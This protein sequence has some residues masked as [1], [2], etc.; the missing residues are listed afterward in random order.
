MINQSV[1]TVI[2]DVFLPVKSTVCMGVIKACCYVCGVSEVCR[3]GVAWGRPQD[4]LVAQ[5]SHEQLKSDEGKDA[6]AED[7]QDH[8]ISQLLHRLDK[9]TNDGFQA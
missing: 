8:D 6:E 4:T 5:V 9:C 1:F 2:R 3:K 7:S